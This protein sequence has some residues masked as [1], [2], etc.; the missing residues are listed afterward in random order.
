LAAYKSNGVESVGVLTEK[1]IVDIPAIWPGPNSPRNII[2][3]LRQDAAAKVKELASKSDIVIPVE[4][5]KL[6][7]PISRPGKLLALAGNY[8]EHIKEASLNRG[9]KLGLWRPKANDCPKAVPQANFN[10]HRADGKSHGRYEQIDM[11]LSWRSW[12]TPNA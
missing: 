2:D 8:G 5:I 12:S 10:H 11:S 3:I 6:L 1:A 9:F 4:N 7:A